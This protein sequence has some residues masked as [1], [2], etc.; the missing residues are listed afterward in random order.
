MKMVAIPVEVLADIELLQEVECCE[1]HH[2]GALREDLAQSAS[3]G[4]R[5]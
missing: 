5:S 2:L 4:E 1:F 3:M